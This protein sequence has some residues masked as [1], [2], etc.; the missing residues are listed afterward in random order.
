MPALDPHRSA[1]HPKAARLLLAQSARGLACSR[2]VVHRR[3]KLPAACPAALP[4]LPAACAVRA[5]TAAALAGR[6]GWAGLAG[7]AGWAPQSS[8]WVTVM[9][10][11]MVGSARGATRV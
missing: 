10:S 3:I 6:L 11:L 9:S 1:E 5:C 8:F 4:N 2:V 7:L